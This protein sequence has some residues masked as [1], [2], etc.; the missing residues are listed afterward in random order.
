MTIPQSRPDLAS[1]VDPPVPPLQPLRALRALNLLR[2]NPGDT[3]QV[4]TIIEAMSGQAPL[5]NLARCRKH[6]AGRQLLRDRPNILAHLSDRAALERLPRGSLAEA[7]LSFIDREGISAGGLVEASVEGRLAK[8]ARDSDLSYM[9]DRLRDSHDLWHAAT[10]Y[11]GDVIGEAALLAFSVAQLRNP[12][13]AVIVLAALAN[14]RAAEASKLVTRAFRDGVRAAW[15]PVVP[16]EELLP[17]P[18][19]QV[20]STLRITPARAYTLLRQPV[21]APLQQAR[22]AS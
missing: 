22:K 12:G 10:G 13:M 6:P 4:F 9:R 21:A 7:Y 5:R 15:F 18:L 3:A 19:E 14:L 1:H 20:R 8:I 17:L 16:W 2:L 11:H